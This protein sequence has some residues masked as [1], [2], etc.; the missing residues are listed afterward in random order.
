MHEASICTTPYK[1]DVCETLK[2]GMKGWKGQHQ[3]GGGREGRRYGRRLFIAEVGTAETN[4]M[5]ESKD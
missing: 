2:G 1:R 3:R 5:K 4:M